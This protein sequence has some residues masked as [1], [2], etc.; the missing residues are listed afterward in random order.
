MESTRTPDPG[1]ALRLIA[2]TRS[3]LADRLITPWWYHPAFAL[4]VGAFVASFAFDSTLVTCIALGLYLGG[5]SALMNAYR[6]KTG[7]WVNGWRAGRA[8]RLGVLIG[9]L[10]GVAIVG[11]VVLANLGVEIAPV[12]AGVLLVPALV[13][14]GRR[15]DDVL[16]ADLR[17]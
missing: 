6:R 4:L 3:D 5:I 15:F 16:R 10:T 1:E 9:V 14:L 11:S 8:S 12:L 17:A 7:V 2:G 13:L